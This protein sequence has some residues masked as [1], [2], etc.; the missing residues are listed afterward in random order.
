MHRIPIAI[1]AL[2]LSVPAC[3]ALGQDGDSAPTMETRRSL[4]PELRFENPADMDS[5]YLNPYIEVVTQ[6][7]PPISGLERSVIY[8]FSPDCP[9][10]H[11][12]HDNI[13]HW[14][15]TLPEG[16]RF[17]PVAIAGPGYTAPSLIGYAG[18][19]EA[20]SGGRF[21]EDQ[22]WHLLFDA[23]IHRGWNTDDID[24]AVDMAVQ[25][26]A[27]EGEIRRILD[28]SRPAQATIDTAKLQL[29]YELDRTPMLVV[30]DKWLTHPD[31]VGSNPLNLIQVANALVSLAIRGATDLRETEIYGESK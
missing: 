15:G 28:A 6:G 11:K 5:A 27:N 17:M 19:L 10:S 22:Y 23:A 26:G 13:M 31:L 9:A 1:T 16:W 21:A 4:T 8:F 14:G 12:L 18:R 20:M 2:A 25:A 3:N 29:R 7:A 24:G 30:A